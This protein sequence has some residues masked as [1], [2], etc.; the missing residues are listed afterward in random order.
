M[1][2]STATFEGRRILAWG[3]IWACL[4]AVLES[5]DM[6]PG[7]WASPQLFLWW[8]T[9]WALPLWWLIGALLLYLTNRLQ[10]RGALL[11]ATVALLVVLP[12][13]ALIQARL[14]AAMSQMTRSLPFLS[15]FAEQ[16]GVM[17]TAATLSAIG[18]YNS[19]V[20]FFHGALLLTVY[21]LTMRSE[22][23]HAM[24]HASA[25]A[26][27]RMQGLLD[28]ERLLALQ[29]QIAPSLVLEIMREL[30]QRYRRDPEAAERLL[31]ALVEFLRCASHGLRRSTST[32][33]AE[34]RLA[35]AF[36]TLQQE[37][38]LASAWRIAVDRGLGKAVTTFP[39]L[40]MLRLLAL[41]EGG[42]PLLR[43]RAE[44]S[45][46][47]LSLHGLTHDLP[48]ELHQ[49]ICASLRALHGDRFRIERRAS[50]LYELSIELLHPCLKEGLPCPR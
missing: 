17:P 46:T 7:R 10:R 41:G 27:N 19:W 33:E 15:R 9:Y 16:L 14:S 32:V 44:D 38:G 49:E 35:G 28:A 45:L 37:R 50:Q 48:P 43:V 21:L 20:Y 34:I 18:L 2:V 13:P 26:R 29:T 39:S 11:A 31:D 36:A 40:L 24:L 30:E 3:F 23:L 8:L 5:L 1:S 12:L 22:R 47:M 42:R 4:V 25:M 6:S